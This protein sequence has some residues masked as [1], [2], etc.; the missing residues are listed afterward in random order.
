MN[1]DSTPMLTCKLLL[2]RRERTEREKGEL[3]QQTQAEV[4]LQLLPLLDSFEQ[5]EAQL[6]GSRASEQQSENERHVHYV[7]GALR[8]QLDAILRRVVAEG[9]CKWACKASAVS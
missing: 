5:A 6:G 2:L 8:K 9:A 3:S 7:Y 1:L 4:A